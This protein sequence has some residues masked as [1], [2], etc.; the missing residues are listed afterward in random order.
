MKV[1]VDEIAV[2]AIEECLLKGVPK[3]LSPSIVIS[4]DDE[5]V[6]A[7]AAESEDA[8]AERARAEAEIEVLTKARAML[9]RL[10]QTHPREDHTIRCLD[11]STMVSCGPVD[12]ARLTQAAATRRALSSLSNSVSDVSDNDRHEDMLSGAARFNQT[13]S[14]RELELTDFRD[15]VFPEQ[16]DWG[17][18]T[19]KKKRQKDKKILS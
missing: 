19:S 4:L 3:L 6:F 1:L 9:T 15:D 2:L 16:P 10:N 5:T 7:I 13:S 12:V 11:S 17:F 18:S 14:T 8:G